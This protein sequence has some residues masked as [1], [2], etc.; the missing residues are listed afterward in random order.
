MIYKSVELEKKEENEL[1]SS[2]INQYI[3]F[4]NF[5][6][7]EKNQILKN[8]KNEEIGILIII[9]Q[10]ESKVNQIKYHRDSYININYNNNYNFLNNN[11]SP[12]IESNY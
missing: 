3:K 8:E 7:Y 6:I 10:K 11:Y 12:K 1:I 5:N 4:R 9:F 2:N